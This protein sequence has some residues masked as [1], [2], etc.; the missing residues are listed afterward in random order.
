MTPAK[1]VL[2][3]FQAFCLAAMF[4]PL[5]VIF[6]KFLSAG[7]G[8]SLRLIAAGKNF[9]IGA[10]FACTIILALLALLAPAL[11]SLFGVL[12]CQALGRECAG[13]GG[14]VSPL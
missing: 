7:R 9:N 11:S 12:E 10:M 13:G 4:S 6:A 2:L 3:N 1:I 14:S 8:L 5:S